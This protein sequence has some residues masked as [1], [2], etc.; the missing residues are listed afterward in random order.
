MRIEMRLFC[1]LP[2]L[3][4]VLVVTAGAAEVNGTLAVDPARFAGA[5]EL[6]RLLLYTPNPLEQGSSISHWDIS[7]TPDLLMEPFASPTV[8]LGEVDLTLPHFRDLGWPQGSSVITIRVTDPEGEGFN[9]PTVVAAAPDNPG[10]TTLGGQRLAALQ[11]VAGVWAAQLGSSVEINIEAAFD[12]LDCGPNPEDGA[13]LA[14]AGSQFLFFD[15]PNAPRQGTW[16]HG[17]LA[18]A[19]AGENLSTTEDG[20]P[21][22]AGELIITFNSQIDEECLGSGYRYY[23]GLDGN[24]PPGQAPFSS[25]ALHEISHGLGFANFINDATGSPPVFTGIPPMPD[26]YSVYTFDK[27]EGL[28]WSEMTNT[29][30]SASA[31]NTNQVVW[32]GPQTTGAAPAFLDNAP[33]LTIN[34]PSSIEGSYA[35]QP[36]QFGPAIDLTGISGDLAVVADGSENP[37]L[38][39]ESL[40]NGEEISGRIAVVDRGECFFTDKVKNAQIAGAVAVLV[41]NNDPAGLPPMGGDDATIT[42]PSAGISQADGELIKTALESRSVIIRRGGMRVTP[43][44]TVTP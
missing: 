40:V 36:A 10:G 5:D 34:S 11:W 4:L 27:D 15:F 6:D 1:L 41:V 44:G 39:C 20:Y 8:P 2:A 23:Y 31:V 42:I 12:E 30:R 13:V 28:H 9:D 14:A 35:V 33:A 18:E 22:E 26:I 43:A 21:P 19:L 24:T 32:D 29:Q 3:V 38:G 7:A 17:A 25:V 16:Y 37:T